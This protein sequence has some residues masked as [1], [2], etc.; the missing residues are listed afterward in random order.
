MQQ[1]PVIGIICTGGITKLFLLNREVVRNKP[2]WAYAKS[3]SQFL[4]T[5]LDCNNLWY[6]GL[7][8]VRGKIRVSI[9]ICLSVYSYSLL[10]V[11]ARAGFLLH[12]VC[13]M[14]VVRSQ[15]DVL[16]IRYR[17]FLTL[18][19]PVIVPLKDLNFEALSDDCK[20]TL[21]VHL[22]GNMPKPPFVK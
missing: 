6:I 13:A 3:V 21:W 4:L 1:N 16:D 20:M 15:C 18:S 11:R 10:I 19:I 12:H 14:Q 5:F 2:W 17:S 8:R 7:S 9:I 22:I